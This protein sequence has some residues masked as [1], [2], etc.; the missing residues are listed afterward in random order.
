[1]FLDTR[2]TNPSLVRC[3]PLSAVVVARGVARR[4][5]PVRATPVAVHPAAGRR[6]PRGEPR[7]PRRRGGSAD[8]LRAPSPAVL[9]QGAV[10]RH[11]GARAGRH[12]GPP[13]HQVLRASAPVAGC[14]NFGLLCVHS[15]QRDS[16]V[17]VRRRV[18][19][20]IAQ[21]CAN[22]ADGDT[23]ESSWAQQ[24]LP[25]CFEVCRS[26]DAAQR[27]V[28]TLARSCC[29]GGGW[30]V[31]VP[32]CCAAWLASCS[33]RS[34]W[35][36]VPMRYVVLSLVWAWAAHLLTRVRVAVHYRVLT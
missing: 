3:H 33:C 31:T 10:V 2:A 16:S 20:V 28:H 25:L 6:L 30:S 13:D 12:Q 9:D 34:C 4:V 15:L 22:I 8:G 24:V 11:P 17:V 5:G 14:A 21:V 29:C 32:V 7:S 35:S 18:C 26:S 36:S 27:C 1:M 23:A 19:L